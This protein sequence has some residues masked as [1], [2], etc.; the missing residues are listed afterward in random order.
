MVI[1]DLGEYLNITEPC[2]LCRKQ[3]ASVTGDKKY[4]IV[5]YKELITNELLKNTMH[6]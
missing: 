3:S 6:S 1:A 2:R 5:C 4:C